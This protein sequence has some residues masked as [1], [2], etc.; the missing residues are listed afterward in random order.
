MGRALSYRLIHE[1]LG[2]FHY[3]KADVAKRNEGHK[4]SGEITKLLANSAANVG[5]ASVRKLSSSIAG[6]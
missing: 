6:Q 4:V 5:V 2:E 3:E 1:I